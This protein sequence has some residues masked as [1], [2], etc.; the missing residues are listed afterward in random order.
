[1]KI[2]TATIGGIS[3]EPSLRYDYDYHEYRRETAGASY[4]FSDLFELNNPPAVDTDD[5]NVDFRY[6][7]I[8][9]AD[10]DGGIEPE[11]LNFDDRDLLTENYYKKIEEGDI[12]SVSEG[13]I[14]LS[15][16]RPNLRK[17]VRITPDLADCY[18]T[19]AFISLFPRRL[20]VILHYALRTLFYKNL[21]A[22]SR[23]GKGYPTLNVNDLR[24]M[25]FDKSIIDT[26][27]SQEE[28]LTREIVEIEG[29][30]R[31]LKATIRPDADIINEVFEREFGFDYV[32]FERLKAQKYFNSSAM[33]FSNNDDLRF[34]AKFHR[35]AGS[36]VKEQLASVTQK[37]IKH[38]LAEPIV[39]GASVS[40]A[41]YS[42]DG[43]YYYI[44]MATIKK[45]AFDSESAQTVT[46]EYSDAKQAKTIRKGDIILARSGEGTIGKVALIDDEGIK[47]VFADFTMRI[48]LTGYN[49]RFAYYYF[50]TA[51]FRYLVE[52]YKKGLG[53]NTNIF[54]STVQEFPLIG[55]SV[56]E[57]QRIVDEIQAELDRNEES[58]NTIAGLCGQIETKIIQAVAPIQYDIFDDS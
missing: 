20:P 12:I 51:Y 24:F 39:L 23:Q 30:I 48:R 17:F 42:E 53:N 22:I 44:S 46:E 18:F 1:M 9:N 49:Q 32:E 6:C 2:L 47:G 28:V 50:R 27:T 7:E 31:T 55:I 3:R 37:K 35:D 56:A 14:L 33:A 34:S 10:K 16:V 13:D 45:W 58:R 8:G 21:I 25:Q 29:Q 41:N 36:F 43:E 5:L 26:L 57:Q 38:Y 52:V 40:P 15:K 54:P 19:S 4:K 11:L